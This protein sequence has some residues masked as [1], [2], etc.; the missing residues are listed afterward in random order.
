MYCDICN[1][2][3]TL[4]IYTIVKIYIITVIFC[5]DHK[6]SQGF[7]NNKLSSYNSYKDILLQYKVTSMCFIYFAGLVNCDVF[8]SNYENIYWDELY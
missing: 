1:D 2:V 3:N 7:Y 4:H 6:K 8:D 5:D